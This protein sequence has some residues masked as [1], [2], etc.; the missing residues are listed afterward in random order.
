M[1]GRLAKRAREVA[2]VTVT[3]ALEDAVDRPVALSQVTK[4]IVG[5]T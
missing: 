2:F 1:V 5:G 3:A 4:S